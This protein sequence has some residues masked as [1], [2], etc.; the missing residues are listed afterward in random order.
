MYVKRSP[1]KVLRLAVLALSISF[2][3]NLIKKS[4]KAAALEGGVSEK[5]LHCWK[6]ILRE[7]G[8]E[9]FSALKPGRRKVGGPSLAEGETLLVYESVNRLLADEKKAEGRK[10]CFSAGSKE[11]I[12]KE[13]DRLKKDFGLSH[14]R[15][16]GLTGI[17]SG[18]IRLW[19]RKHGAG[20]L[21]AL[22]PGSRAPKDNRKKLPPVVIE[23]I[24]HAGR[25]WSRRKI[26]TAEFGRYFR[27]EYREL[28]LKEGHPDI[29]DKTI[30]RYL[31][32]A[33]LISRNQERPE[34]K[35]GS[36]RYYFPGAQ[37]L[38]DTCQVYFLGIKTYVIGV[39]DAF[40][41]DVLSQSSFLRETAKAVEKVIRT[42]LGEAKKSGVKAG[43]M[44]SDHGRVYKAR[45]TREFLRISGLT[46]IY[47]HPYRPQSKAAIERYFRTLKEV[48]YGAGVIKLFIKGLV[49][50]VWKRTLNFVLCVILQ[51]IRVQYNGRIQQADGKSPGERIKTRHAERM[52]KAVETVLESRKAPSKKESIGTL[53]S[54]LELTVPK[55]RAVKELMSYSAESIEEAAQA[56]RRKLV[57]ENMEPLH[58]WYYLAKVV[59]NV[60]ERKNDAKKKDAER[61]IKE[62]KERMHRAEE[63]RKVISQEEWNKKHPEEAL[64]ESVE[65]HLLFHP[66]RIGSGFYEGRIMEYTSI[67]LRGHSKRTA[68]VKLDKIGGNILS[69]DSVRRMKK[70]AKR[71]GLN[72]PG[73]EQLEEAKSRILELLGETYAGEK[74]RI[75]S[76]QNFR[77]LMVK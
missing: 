57:A 26:N 6:T 21:E 37:I 24:Q 31:K 36:F 39:M 64:Q 73:R 75:P 28:L 45:R 51:G 38:I 30:G 13:R 60:E 19:A 43:A 5:Q 77:S 14:E 55:V 52:E 54:E 17:D 41:R 3:D 65:W 40:S 34:G 72:L 12:L 48:L 1:E 58:R 44:V 27:R 10:R 76:V 47:A 63:R 18:V 2:F 16:A 32:E 15:F 66:K 20:G 42:A 70:K 53:Y 46:A 59:A 68:A 8:L 29:A 71:E 74:G 69:E 33:G 11:R 50:V 7:K 9:A 4:I 22:E 49:I 25:K 35:R 23:R 67:I 62:E 61:I 56:L